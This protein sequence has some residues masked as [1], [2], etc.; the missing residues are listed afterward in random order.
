MR[1]SALRGEGIHLDKP[2]NAVTKDDRQTA[3]SCNF[4]L[5]YGQSAPGLVRY[6]A[7]SYSVTLADD[8]A[9]DIRKTFFRTS[10]K[11]RQW[12]GRSHQEAEQGVKEVRTR[13]GRRRLIPGNSSDWECF[14]ALVNTPVQ[15]GTADG[16][17]QASRAASAMWENGASAMAIRGTAVRGFFMGTG[18]ARI[19]V[20]FQ[21][22]PSSSECS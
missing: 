6:A 17:K 7:T 3:K 19:P 8:Q 4:G 18:Q 12:H 13:P 16:M 5:I 10:S 21:L 14:T 22:P 1:L 20:I 9:Q 15:G 11:L 2:I